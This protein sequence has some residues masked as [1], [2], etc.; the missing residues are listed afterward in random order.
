MPWRIAISSPSRTAILAVVAE[1][2]AV[3]VLPATSIGPGLRKSIVSRG[4][5]P[6]PNLEVALY[7]ADDRRAATEAFA[8]F[9]VERFATR[10]RALR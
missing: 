2:F 6:L 10:S 4:L 3:S 9:I 8:D 1:G 5:P 7:R